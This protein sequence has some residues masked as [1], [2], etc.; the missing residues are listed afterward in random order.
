MVNGNA[1]DGSGAQQ[2]LGWTLGGFV[3]A[4]FVG[5]NRAQS[6][7]PQIELSRFAGPFCVTVCGEMCNRPSYYVVHIMLYRWWMIITF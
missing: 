5:C 3:S 2:Q 4:H 1:V 6:L 7:E